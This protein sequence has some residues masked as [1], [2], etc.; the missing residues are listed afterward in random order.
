M[1]YLVIYLNFD[2]KV[3]LFNAIS[4]VVYVYCL[5]SPE[6]PNA[7]DR[8]SFQEDLLRQF[9]NYIAPLIFLGLLFSSLSS[10]SSDQKEVRNLISLSIANFRSKYIFLIF[11]FSFSII[12]SFWIF[13]LDG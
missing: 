9:Q 7:D 11:F 4:I 8:G 12:V 3:P 1:T 10:S 5:F 13:H 6:D 2:G